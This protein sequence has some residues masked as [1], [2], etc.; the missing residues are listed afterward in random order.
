MREYSTPEV[1]E[2]SASARLSDTVSDRADS[3]PGAVLLRRKAGPDGAAAGSDDG[4]PARWHD[5]TARQFRDDVAA[6][7]RGLRRRSSGSGC[8]PPTSPSRTGT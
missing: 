1:T 2:V 4:Q 8:W 3:D 7:A 6:L 5:V